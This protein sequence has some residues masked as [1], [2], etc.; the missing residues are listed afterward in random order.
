MNLQVE[1]FLKSRFHCTVLILLGGLGSPLSRHFLSANI[2]SILMWALIIFQAK[3]LHCY[4]S[5]FFRACDLSLFWI[6]R[7]PDQ[8]NL[9]SCMSL[10]MRW[11]STNFYTFSFFFREIVMRKLSS[12]F[13]FWR[14][15]GNKRNKKTEEKTRENTTGYIF[16]ICVAS[17]R[18][19]QAFKVLF[20]Y[21]SYNLY[22]NKS[23]FVAIEPDIA[24]FCNW[25]EKRNC[26]KLLLPFIARREYLKLS[27]DTILFDALV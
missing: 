13:Q 20:H 19:I 17:S 6:K 27:K 10:Y 15:N 22:K 25:F 14:E 8:N 5:I 11:T 1:I 9:Y 21:F 16:R 18:R 24:Y 3:E 7:G 23:S 12:S 2:L 26:S 4:R